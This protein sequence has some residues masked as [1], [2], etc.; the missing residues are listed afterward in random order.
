MKDTERDDMEADAMSHTPH[1]TFGVIGDVHAH[2]RRLGLV[3]ARLREL[4]ALDG[5]L[6]VGDLCGEPPFALGRRGPAA[7]TW[8]ADSIRDVLAEVA[9]LGVPLAWVPGNHDPREH[10]DPRNVDDRVTLIAGVRVGGIGGAGPARFGF[11]YEWG[12]DETRARALA[13]PACELVISHTPP[14]DSGLDRVARG[15]HAVGSV[16]IRELAS[17]H[18]GVLVCGH[19]HEAPG[20]WIA[21]DCLCAN[22]GGLGEP[23][24][25]AQVGVLTLRGPASARE[26]QLVLED[27]DALSER[28]FTH[29]PLALALEE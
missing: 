4:P 26:Y 21:N 15:G 28:R 19:I 7:L 18:R 14:H 20:V 23:Y 25:R 13:L 10:D 27:L 22:V 2:A 16:A 3:L 24:G 17:R 8:R 9:T 1:L 12:E 5:V 6:L 11:P 29:G